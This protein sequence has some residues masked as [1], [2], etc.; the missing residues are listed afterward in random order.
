MKTSLLTLASC[1][2][3]L[4]TQIMA[5]DDNSPELDPT[6]PVED[7]AACALPSHAATTALEAFQKSDEEWQKT[8]SPDQFRV[9][10]KHG[11]EPAFRNAY[12]NNKDT[13][14]YLCAACEAPLFASGEKFDSGTG[15]PSFWDSIV[16]ENVGQTVDTS[17]GMT[18]TEVHCKRCG[19]HLGHLFPDGPKPTSQRYC[20][21]STS[22]EFVQKDEIE[23]RD[24]SQF[25][26]HAR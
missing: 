24:L 11:T 19:G 26:D 6:Q 15:W 23:A 13:G 17:Y 1:L 16:P 4:T 18:R 20:I 8:L 5:T 3:I 2:A 12:W 21:N 7:L 9:M 22:I 25:A 10:R 14:L